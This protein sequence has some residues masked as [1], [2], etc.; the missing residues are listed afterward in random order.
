MLRNG[1]QYY[2]WHLRL[3]Q[4]STKI[5]TL[6]PLFIAEILQNIQE[7]SQIIFTK[8]YLCKFEN[9][10]LDKDG[11][12]VNPYLKFHHVYNLDFFTFAILKL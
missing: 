9:R 7:T 11:N 4:N 8:Y 3:F 6:D 10:N 2:C 5:G 12:C 1:F